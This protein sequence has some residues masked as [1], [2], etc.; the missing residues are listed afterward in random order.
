MSNDSIQNIETGEAHDS[1][2]TNVIAESE[3]G[4]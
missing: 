2:K 1:Q 4:R 3:Q